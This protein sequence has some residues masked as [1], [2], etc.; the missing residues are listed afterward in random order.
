M[1][2][3]DKSTGAQGTMRIRDNGGSSVELWLYTSS[4][5]TWFGSGFTFTWSS[6]NGSGSFN[7][8]YPAGSGWRHM[9]TIPVTANGNVSWTMPY[10][11]TSAFGGPTTQTVYISRST[12]PPAPSKV[13]FSDIKHESVVTKFSS[14]GTGGLPI[15]EWQMS[16]GTNGSAIEGSGNAKYSSTGTRTITGLMPG[17]YYA[18]WARGRNANG[19]GPWSSGASFYTLAGCSVKDAGVWK[20]AVPYVKVAGVWVPAVPYYKATAGWYPTTS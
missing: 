10:T 7:N 20:K 15:I 17:Q 18:A 16:F 11:G 3:Y 6:P 14:N 1:T 19:W 8:N 5:G 4:P 13:A 2:D 12:V 9:A